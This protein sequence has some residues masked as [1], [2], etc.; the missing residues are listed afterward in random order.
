MDELGGRLVAELG[1]DLAIDVHGKIW[2]IEINSK[3]SKT[4]DTVINP[5]SHFR[6]SV[7]RLIDYVL[8]LSQQGKHP[9][10]PSPS[11]TSVIMRRQRR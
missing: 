9:P 11:T 8:Y 1:I 10:A 4:D 6:P 3:P 2:L 7:L 5:N